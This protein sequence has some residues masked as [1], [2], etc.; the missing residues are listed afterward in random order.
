EDRNCQLRARPGAS[1][2]GALDGAIF[3]AAGDWADFRVSM[4]KH[5][6]ALP[7]FAVAVAGT[8]KTATG[9]A[10][11][12]QGLALR[13]LCLARRAG[14]EPELAK[15]RIVAAACVLVAD[16]ARLAGRYEARGQRAHLCGWSPAFRVL[17]PSDG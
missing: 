2:R 16:R 3:G 8:A 10:R 5:G 11:R 7:G 4:E 9:D 17:S 6:Q 12:S 14:A 15:P 1:Q 13:I